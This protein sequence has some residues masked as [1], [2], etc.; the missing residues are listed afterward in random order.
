MARIIAL[1]VLTL[2]TQ[3]TYLENFIVVHCIFQEDNEALDLHL[4]SKWMTLSNILNSY[5]IVILFIGGTELI[6][7]QFLPS[8]T[9]LMF[10]VVYSSRSIF[11]V[12]GYR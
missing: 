12:I 5:S 2:N 8:M 11:S 1:V 9:G 4:D 3:K 7:A 10:G 6:C